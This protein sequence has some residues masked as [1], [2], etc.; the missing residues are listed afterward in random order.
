VAF[1]GYLKVQPEKVE[2]LR[3]LRSEFGIEEGGGRGG[4][5]PDSLRSAYEERLAEIDQRWPRSTVRDF[6]DHIE[7]AVDIVGIEHVGI[8]SDFDGGGGIDGWDDASETANV[9][10]E[11][12][13]RGYSDDQIAQLWGGNLLRVW[14]EA[15]QIAL[16][17][18]AATER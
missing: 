3:V 11:L 17:E 8:S 15:E 5:P 1:D 13:R 10:A 12:I 6:V 7:Y 16:G 9:T 18:G 2:A 4:A 14:S